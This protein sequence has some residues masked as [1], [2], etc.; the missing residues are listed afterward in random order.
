M[1]WLVFKVLLINISQGWSNVWVTYLVKE[2]TWC[3]EDSWWE[4]RKRGKEGNGGGRKAGKQGKGKR[5]KHKGEAEI[6]ALSILFPCSWLV[7]LQPMLSLGRQADSSSAP[8]GGVTQNSR[9]NFL[10]PLGCI[11]IFL[12]SLI[13]FTFSLFLSLQPVLFSHSLPN[14]VPNQFLP[15]VWKTSWNN[16]TWGTTTGSWSW[17]LLDY[18][19]I[20]PSKEPFGQPSDWSIFQLNTHILKWS[21]KWLNFWPSCHGYTCSTFSFSSSKVTAWKWLPLQDYRTY[22]GTLRIQ[23]KFSLLLF[24]LSL[25]Q[26]S[27]SLSLFLLVNYFLPFPLDWTQDMLL[28]LSVIMHTRKSDEWTLV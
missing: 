11:K 23:C 27:F 15:C 10:S 19:V 14:L 4:E 13:C 2:W 3:I 22:F 21:E 18:S 1:C 20:D 25:T 16:T 8:S 17:P 12:F 26:F 9:E 7:S 5:R 6:T 28:P 24:F